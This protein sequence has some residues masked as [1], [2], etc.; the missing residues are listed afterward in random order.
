[1]SQATV[2]QIRQFVIENFLFGQDDGNLGNDDSFL[3]KGIIDSTGILELIAF[4]EKTYEI[5]IADEDLVPGNLDTVN[6]VVQF[7]N[8]KM[9]LEKA[10]RRY[11]ET[12]EI[13][14]Y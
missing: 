8:S 2:Q 6:R 14:I 5:K 13:K 10:H 3:E 11:A 7:V 12:A 4:L 1:M 9:G